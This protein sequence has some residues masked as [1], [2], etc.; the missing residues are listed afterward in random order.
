[1]KTKRKNKNVNFKSK[2]NSIPLEKQLNKIYNYVNLQTMCR[3]N[4]TCCLVGCPQMHFSEFSSLINEVWNTSNKLNKID[5]ICLSV[6]YFFRSE[7][8]KWGI[9]SLQKKCLLLDEKNRG[10]KYYKNRPLNCR[11]YGLW[12]KKEYKE[13]VD[14]FEKAYK[15]LLKR[16]ELPLN[17]QC[18]YVKRIDE[19]IELTME[20]IN[21]LFSQLD[22]LDKKI[23]NFSD[24]YIFNN[25][26]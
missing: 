1:M 3:R 21:D 24:V 6:E 4:L 10:C 11:L 26:P 25:D 22:V 5:L 13:R 23:G 18:P 2:S 16:K 19:S 20:V 14:K 12:P 15:G 17:K 8:E 9:Q 7:F